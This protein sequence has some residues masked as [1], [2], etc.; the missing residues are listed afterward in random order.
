MPTD[1]ERLGGESAVHAHVKAIVEAFFDDMI[2]GFQFVGRSR[3]RIM[4]HESELALR[5]LG[6]SSTY[7][8]RPIARVHGRLRIN[9][10]Q[11]RRRLAIVQTVLADRG[12]PA[13]IIERWV[14][15]DR[16]LESQIVDGTDCVP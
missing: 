1:L 15:H 7:T 5:H 2:I 16:A 13:D 3:E 10:G 6:A 8:G 11:F 4:T 12:V 9:R 14:A